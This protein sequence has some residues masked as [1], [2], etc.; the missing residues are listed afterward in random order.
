MRRLKQDTKYMAMNHSA[1]NKC[2]KKEDEKGGFTDSRWIFREKSDS[3][4][5]RGAGGEK[6][7]GVKEILD[8][9]SFVNTVALFCPMLPYSHSFV[10]LSIFKWTSL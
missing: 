9:L 8:S 5:S 7:G 6:L 10:F 1:G 3:T 4:C 2:I